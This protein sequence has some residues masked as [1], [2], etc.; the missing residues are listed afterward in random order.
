MSGT[1]SWEP[2]GA[3]GQSLRPCAVGSPLEG[4]P[5]N[6]CP[7][8][9]KAPPCPR[10]TPS[11]RSQKDLS[12]PASPPKLNQGKAAGTRQ[13]RPPGGPRQLVAPS[14]R[15]LIHLGRNEGCRQGR[16]EGGREGRAL[17]PGEGGCT[18]GDGREQTLL[19]MPAASG[20][21]EGLIW[22]EAREL[23]AARKPPD[24]ANKRFRI[25]N[26]KTRALNREARGQ[27]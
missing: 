11:S 14:C 10:A 1:S 6:P 19:R 22:P 7:G 4:P 24:K 3:T 13:P 17:C 27:H 15:V 12:P 23:G 21:G 25:E 8:R 20:R 2:Q 9:K 16:T 5:C 18:L 26:G